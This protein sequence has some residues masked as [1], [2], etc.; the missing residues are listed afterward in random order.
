MAKKKVR[1]PDYVWVVVGQTGEHA[2]T[3]QWEV[4]AFLDSEV[5]GEY[6]NKANAVA[7]QL[8]VKYRH[9]NITLK[10]GEN[11]YDLKMQMDYTGTEYSVRCVSLLYE[12][13]D[14]Q[15]PM[16]KA[17]CLECASEHELCDNRFMVHD[18]ETEGADGEIKKHGRCPG[19]GKV[20]GATVSVQS[21]LSEYEKMQEDTFSQVQ[22]EIAKE[23]EDLDPD[24]SE[25]LLL[26]LFEKRKKTREKEKVAFD[27]ETV[28]LDP[29]GQPSQAGRVM[30]PPQVNNTRLD[31]IRKKI[32]AQMAEDG[33]S[34][35]PVGE[36][37]PRIM[38]NRTR[39]RSVL[40]CKHPKHVVPAG[41]CPCI[42]ECFCR[43]NGTC[44]GKHQLVRDT[45]EDTRSASIDEKTEDEIEKI[46]SRKRRQ[47]E[48]D[49]D[50]F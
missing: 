36:F 39:V 40:K 3:V 9:Q 49:E 24:G 34:G 50:D 29:W 21:V 10:V 47:K 41:K 17:L 11:P 26:D 33:E 37:N 14:H 6:C 7:R 35:N 12:V 22:E 38:R 2:D 13:P 46:I 32:E 16:G 44:V 15:D 19:S 4:A 30:N 45:L 27:T 43:H 8:D 5:A 1:P 25:Q 42:P 23:D 28:G 18:I 31:A 48:E 20:P